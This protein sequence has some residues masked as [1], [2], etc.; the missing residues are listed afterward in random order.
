MEELVVLSFRDYLK[1]QMNMDKQLDREFIDRALHVTS[2]NL[3]AKDFESTKY[4]KEIQFLFGTHFFPKFDMTYTVDKVDKVQL[5]AAIKKLKSESAAK[6]SALHSYNLKGIGPGEA[7]L[8]FLINNARLGGGG[9]AGLD[10]VVGS[11]G[12]EVKAVTVT[13]DGYASNF[14]LGGTFDTSDIIN[15]IRELKKKVGGTGAEVNQSEIKVIKSKFPK[16]YAAIEKKYIETA[17]ESYFK[18]HP[19]IFIYNTG[20]NLGLI[21]AVKTVK[22]EDIQLE[23]VTSG[24]IKPRVKL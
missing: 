20:P 7:T 6:F 23:R 3:T 18:H 12:Y 2:F 11:N 4:K 16:E 17:Y 21:A 14:K 24:V 13:S 19:I 10:L 8:Y 1:E 9:S 15:Q 5:N 22:K